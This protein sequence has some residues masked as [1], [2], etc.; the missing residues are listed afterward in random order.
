MVNICL[1]SATLSSTQLTRYFYMKELPSKLIVW[2]LFGSINQKRGIVHAMARWNLGPWKP[3]L[4]LL[5]PLNYYEHNRMMSLWGTTPSSSNQGCDLKCLCIITGFFPLS[6][7]LAR[8]SINGFQQGSVVKPD[9][10]SLTGRSWKCHCAVCPLF[11]Y[12][13]GIYRNA[14]REFGFVEWDVVLLFAMH[15]LALEKARKN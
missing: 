4:G 7:C 12:N 8:W 5:S 13:L 9:S 2:L 14:L 1:Q 6:H 10:P 3:S 11:V 15:Y